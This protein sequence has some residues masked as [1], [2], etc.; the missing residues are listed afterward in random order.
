[1][2]T[3]AAASK[4]DSMVWSRVS[5]LLLLSACLLTAC[6]KES[7]SS[8]AP[9]PPEP[10]APASDIFAGVHPTTQQLLTGQRTALDVKFAPITLQVPPGWE[11]KSYEQATLVTIEGSTP[12]DVIGISVPVLRTISVD[13]EKALEAQ[14]AQD[15]SRHPDLLHKLGVRQ[16][17]GGTVIE[18][19]IVDPIRTATQTIGDTTQPIQTMQWTF[20]VC[21]PAADGKEYTVY[22]LKFLGM[23]LSQYKLDEGFLRPIIDSLTYTPSTDLPPT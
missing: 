9:P 12:T 3:F 23:T 19:L 11:V 6:D 16:I 5:R 18:H 22:D 13:Q 15:M 1:M 8:S 20:S 17:T 14:A 4:R 10:V 2:P 21:I 7:D